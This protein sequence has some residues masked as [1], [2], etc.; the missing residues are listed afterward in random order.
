MPRVINSFDVF[1][2][3]MLDGVVEPT[4]VLRKWRS[5][6]SIGPGCSSD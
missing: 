5:G 2:T 1:D 4:E 6:L 3:L